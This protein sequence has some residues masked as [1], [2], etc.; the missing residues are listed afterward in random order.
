MLIFATMIN[1]VDDRAFMQICSRTNDRRARR[2]FPV[3]QRQYS[4]ASFT[5]KA[6]ISKVNERGWHK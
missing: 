2:N 3:Q 5:R 4:D 1:D 6:K